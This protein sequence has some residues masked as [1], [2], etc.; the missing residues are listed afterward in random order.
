M[1]I[2]NSICIVLT[3]LFLTG[4]IFIQIATIQGS[5]RHEL[6]REHFDNYKC[7][8][9]IKPKFFERTVMYLN[10]SPLYDN[11]L[12]YCDKHD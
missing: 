4:T 10:D 3:I 7:W 2:F 9:I 1:K 6:M 5:N 8:P 12:N 11:K